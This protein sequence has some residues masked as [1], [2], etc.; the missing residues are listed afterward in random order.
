[1]ENTELKIEKATPPDAERW[2]QIRKKC[3]LQIYPNREH[4]IT[5]EDILLKDFDSPEKIQ[6]WRD[7]FVV[8]LNNATYYTA[9]IGDEIVA[10]CIAYGEQPVAE[11]G[12]I[13]VDLKYQHRGIGTKLMN[14]AMSHFDPEKKVCLKVVT[15]N[16]RAI[17]FYEKLGFKITGPYDDPHGV[18]P[19][20][21]S[22]PEMEMV[23]D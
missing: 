12:A 22:L 2:C 15:Y 6:M 7:S 10:I 14:H 17:E 19:N 8:P 21:K 3:W 1:M 20:G 16:M 18:L 5:R 4:N 23:R 9:K 13:Y 11:I